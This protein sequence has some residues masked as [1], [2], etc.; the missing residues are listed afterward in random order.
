MVGG[1]QRKE[2]REALLDAFP[3]V[4][5]FKI[6][7]ADSLDTYL[8]D[9]TRSQAPLE[10]MVFDT[11][12]WAE[13]CGR[14]SQL[15]LGAL[16]SRPGNSRLRSAAANFEFPEA[17]AGELERLTR[18]NV[19]FASPTEWVG[20]LQ[21][22][23]RAV[24]RVEWLNGAFATGFLVGPDLVI[25]G[26]F[27][28][29]DFWDDKKKAETVRFRFDYRDGPKG[30]VEPGTAY[31]LHPGDWRVFK[32]S[33]RD[34]PFAVIRLAEW[35]ADGGPRWG[36]SLSREPTTPGQAAM[37]LQHVQAGPL[38]LAIGTVV[39]ANLQESP[40]QVYYTVSTDHG[41]AGAPCFNTELKVIAMHV[42]RSP[43]TVG[44]KT[45]FGIQMSAILA[46][47]KQNGIAG[48]RI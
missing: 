40:G 6:L 41:S 5:S 25:T 46:H 48:V 23:Q 24:C 17:V 33:N 22:L 2:L 13:R 47:L 8:S 44:E 38:R 42:G 27:V 37:L 4:D 18:S 34:L 1:R 29:H 21:R 45:K 15:V 31:P 28:V 16:S 43:G 30:N 9:I 20:Q 32:S 3:T 35:A 26:D 36:L 11:I 12:E 10:V 39:A 14:L 19:P 7:V